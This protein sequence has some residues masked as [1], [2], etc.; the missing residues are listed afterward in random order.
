MLYIMGMIVCIGVIVACVYFSSEGNKIEKREK[1][2]VDI[3]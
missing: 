3:E 1:N 2:N